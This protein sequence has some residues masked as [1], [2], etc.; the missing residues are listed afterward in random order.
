MEELKK[1]AEVAQ[2]TQE[3][4]AWEKYM[5]QNVQTGQYTYTDP[6]DGTVYEW[7]PEK[8]GWIPK[9]CVICIYFILDYRYGDL[10]EG[11]FLR[12][13]FALN[14]FFLNGYGPYYNLCHQYFY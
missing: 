9:V 2:S 4:P 3:Q 14:V 8:R 6:S 5:Q 1:Q 11:T 10:R 7:D 13:F 12:H